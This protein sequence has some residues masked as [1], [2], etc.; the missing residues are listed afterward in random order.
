MVTEIVESLCGM[1][2]SQHELEKCNAAPSFSVKESKQILAPTK[3]HFE[4]TFPRK[5]IQSSKI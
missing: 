3:I 4:S 5:K 2:V 1:T